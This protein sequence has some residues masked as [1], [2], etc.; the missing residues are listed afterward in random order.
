MHEI[1]HVL[2]LA[3]ILSYHYGTGGTTVT[4]FGDND[5]AGLFYSLPCVIF[6]IAI[7]DIA[8]VSEPGAK[9]TIYQ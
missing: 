1:H 8:R 3:H 9:G 6:L 5:K 2:L 7:L 4:M